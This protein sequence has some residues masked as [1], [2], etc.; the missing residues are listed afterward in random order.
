MRRLLLASTFL[1]SV[2]GFSQAPNEGAKKGYVEKQTELNVKKLT[3]ELD[4]TP[5]QQEKIKPLIAEQMEKKELKKVSF[6]NKKQQGIEASDDEMHELRMQLLDDEIAKK[7]KMKEIL[8]AD[9][10]SKWK[11]NIAAKRAKIEENRKEIKKKRAEKL[12]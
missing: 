4:L 8:T 5:E 7:N 2:L 1:I 12:N 10:Y 11:K 6:I 9:Q 3:L